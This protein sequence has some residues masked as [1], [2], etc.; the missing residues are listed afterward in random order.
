MLTSFLMS[1][2]FASLEVSGGISYNVFTCVY[3]SNFVLCPCCW[4][5]LAVSILWCHVSVLESVAAAEWFWGYHIFFCFLKYL[6]EDWSYH[7]PY[8]FGG[9]H[10]QNL[11]SMMFYLWEGIYF[12]K[13]L[14]SFMILETSRF[15]FGSI[16]VNF[17][18]P[19]FCLVQLEFLIYLHKGSQYFA[20]FISAAAVL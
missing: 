20:F 17:F 14:I 8:I 11:L 2:C 13:D 7:F 1:T 10:L 18:F 6:I 19:G 15:I 3:S 12:S 16:L 4:V 5:R 9:I